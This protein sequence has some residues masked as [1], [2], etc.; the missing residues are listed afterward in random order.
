MQSHLGTS[1]PDSANLWFELANDGLLVIQENIIVDL[2]PAFSKL[3]GFNF[4]EL[5]GRPLETILDDKAHGISEA[6]TELDAA[7]NVRIEPKRT[8]LLHRMG[9]PVAVRV[10]AAAVRH[11]NRQAALLIAEDLSPEL[12]TANELQKARQLESIAALSGGIAHDYNNL[13]TVIIGNI[14]LIQ[15]TVGKV[16]RLSPLLAEV[17]EAASIAKSLTRK[18]ITFSKGGAPCKKAADIVS[19]LKNTTE[20]SLSGSNVVARFQFASDLAKVDVDKTQIGQAIHNLVMN[21]REAMPA[22]GALTV[23]AENR[24]IDNSGYGIPPGPHVWIGI[25]D[26]GCGIDSEHLDR[27][28]DPYFSTKQRGNQK[29]MGLGLSI[30]RSIVQKHNGFLGIDSADG[31][32]TLAE[33]LLPASKEALRDDPADSKDCRTEP[34]QGSGRILVMDDEEMILKLSALILQR[35]GYEAEFSRRGEEAVERYRQAL[36]EGARFDAVIL[37][38]TVRGGMGGLQAMRHLQKIDAGVKA[39]VSSGYSNSPV[40]AEPQ[41]YGFS[42]VVVKPYDLQSLSESLHNLLHNQS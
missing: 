40:M 14:S 3:C 23:R 9:Y 21:A 36:Q 18:L 38:L 1:T 42:G 25:E 4:D 37:D 29:G 35:L 32:G 11:R 7:E 26:E 27:V 33:I 5:A 24:W 20:F 8:N 15:T 22:G 6:I 13:L 28:F 12:K 19:I 10:Q 34:F 31:R 30:C 41:R 2:N 39:L 17:A 16:D